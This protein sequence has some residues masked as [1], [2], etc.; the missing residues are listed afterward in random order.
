MTI[1]DLTKI[2]DRAGNPLKPTEIKG[3]LHPFWYFDPAAE[4]ATKG[5]GGGLQFVV[6]AALVG[7]LLLFLVLK[8]T[9]AHLWD[10]VHQMQFI[11][12]L[13]LLDIIYPPMVPTFVSYFE[14]A[15][16]KL[17]FL[18]GIM[19]KFPEFI[20]NPDDLESHSVLLQESFKEN[21]IF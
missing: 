9:M 14:V 16:G 1:V 11:H 12:Y 13:L 10:M 18:S 8:S 21:D 20:I 17:D 6:L 7:Q 19:P 4:A 15:N 2:S 5:G 3:N